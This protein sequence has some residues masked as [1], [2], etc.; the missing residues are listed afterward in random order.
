MWFVLFNSKK[1]VIRRQDGWTMLLMEDLTKLLKKVRSIRLPSIRRGRIFRLGF[2]I[3]IM[4][5]LVLLLGIVSSLAPAVCCWLSWRFWEECCF[6]C[7]SVWLSILSK[8]WIVIRWGKWHLVLHWGN[9]PSIDSNS[10][11]MFYLLNKLKHIFL[12]YFAV[13]STEVNSTHPTI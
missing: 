7:W 2:I 3:K 5:L 12:L 9:P 11:R 13:T 6:V 1:T 8:K 10:P 4:Q